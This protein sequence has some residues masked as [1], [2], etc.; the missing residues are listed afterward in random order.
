MRPDELELIYQAGCIRSWDQM[1]KVDQPDKYTRKNTH[2]HYLVIIDNM[3]GILVSDI[4]YA[5]PDR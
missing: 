2:E 1:I 5:D 4:P 3:V